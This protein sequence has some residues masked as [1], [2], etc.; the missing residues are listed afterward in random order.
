MSLIKS[1]LFDSL[2]LITMGADALETAGNLRL[3]VI[4]PMGLMN[5]IGPI[6]AGRRGDRMFLFFKF[7]YFVQSLAN[8]RLDIVQTHRGF[9]NRD[10][11]GGF[12]EVEVGVPQQ[13]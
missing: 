12:L 13:V 6:T 7:F 3:P 10:G 1:V 5:P 4:G 2:I 9:K 8:L 11:F